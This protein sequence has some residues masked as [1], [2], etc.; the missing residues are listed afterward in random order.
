MRKGN[1]SKEIVKLAT[2]DEA[3]TRYKLS[4]SSVMRYAT[5]ANA[6]RKIGRSVR[7]DVDVMDQYIKESGGD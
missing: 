5:K 7:I 1:Y 2:V 4:R 3:M 6:V